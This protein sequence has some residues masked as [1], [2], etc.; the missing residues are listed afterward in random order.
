MY[1][2]AVVRAVDRRRD[3]FASLVTLPRCSSA[4]RSVRTTTLRHAS[5]R[6]LH[7]DPA[8]ARATRAAARGV[9]RPILL[10]RRSD[11]PPRRC[12]PLP[13]AR[14]LDSAA[15]PQSTDSPAKE[16]PPKGLVTV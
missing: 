11:P 14:S 13:V 6:T 15:F 5:R 4:R 10:P 1:A 8:S 12:Q 2:L 9:V 3:A 16:W 7:A